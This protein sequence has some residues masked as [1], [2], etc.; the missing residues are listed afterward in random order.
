MFAIH[1]VRSEAFEVCRNTVHH[2]NSENLVDVVANDTRLRDRFI[3]VR[4]RP[5]EQ[6][7]LESMVRYYATQLEESRRGFVGSMINAYYSIVQML[8]NYRIQIVQSIAALPG[9]VL[10]DVP[11]VHANLEQ[12][13]F[14][15]RD[16]L[17]V[18]DSDIILGAL[19]RR[20]VACFTA[21][22]E[23]NVRVR[24]ASK[25]QKINNIFVRAALREVACHP[26]DAVAVKRLCVN[27]LTLQ[28][29]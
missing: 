23:L 29:P 11:V 16:N 14:G 13:R 6:Q 3:A 9:F 27:K 12:G 5:P 26:D 8:S 19:T 15:F 7:E 2:C 20:T 1:I 4:G 17:A 18:G 21:K 22:K 28:R 24:T 10:G 25:V